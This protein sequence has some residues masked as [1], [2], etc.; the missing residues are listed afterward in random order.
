MIQM[1]FDLEV[2]HLVMKKMHF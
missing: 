1:K 2:A